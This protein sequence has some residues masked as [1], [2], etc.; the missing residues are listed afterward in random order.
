MVLMIYKLAFKL[1]EA[2]APTICFTEEGHFFQ[3]IPPRKF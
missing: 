2:G 1:L 3:I